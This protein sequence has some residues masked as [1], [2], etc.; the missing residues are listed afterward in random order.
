MDDAAGLVHIYNFS[1]LLMKVQCQAFKA[2]LCYEELKVIRSYVVS[3]SQD[4][5]TLDLKKL[6][7]V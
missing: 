4:G 2:N 5:T 3:S 6:T 7:E 1:T